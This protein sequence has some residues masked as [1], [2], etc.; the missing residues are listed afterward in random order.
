MTTKKRDRAAYMRQYRARKRE[1]VAEATRTPEPP[2]NAALDAPLGEL[3]A[4]FGERLLVPT[5]PLTGQPF[6]IPPWQRQW[7]IESLAPEV[8]ESGLSV[9]RKNGKSGLVALLVLAFLLRPVRRSTWRAAVVSLTGSL[10]GELL[11]AIVQTATLA[12]QLG[13]LKVRRAPPPGSIEADTG[14]RV[15]FLAS[16]KATGHAIGVD[17]AV[18]DEAGL[19]QETNRELW[20]A[21]YSS[22]SGRDGKLLAISIR[23]D[24]PMFSEMAERAGEPGVVWHEYAAPDDCALDDEQAWHQANPGLATGIKSL[25]YMEDASRKAITIPADA[26]SFRAYDLNQP[27]SPS[28][29]TIC[30]AQD[31]QACEVDDLPPR[32]GYAVVGFDIGGSSSLTALAAFWPATGRLEAWAACGDNPPLLERSRADGVG[33]TYCRMQQRGELA[34][35]PGRV[36]PAAEFLVDCAYRLGDTRVLAAGADRY[37]KAEVLDALSRAGLDWPIE[38]RGQGASGMAD[39]S[40]DVR[41][42]QRLVLGERLKVAPSLLLRQAIAESTIRRDGAGNPALDKRRQHGRID[43]LSAAVIAAGLGE[44]AGVQKPAGSRYRGRV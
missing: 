8:R 28:V 32:D 43:A 25:R 37:R 10:A 35:Y 26:A 20:N 31:W 33:D 39:G 7:L 13:R 36:T 23:G 42:F 38:W 22:T 11:G 5:G 14:A 27:R 44:L 4:R 2:E 34:T 16:D 12:G 30:S 41:A 40:H 6:V 17:L 1:E 15:D 19:L 29:E 9:A 3:V 24:G 21:M 18:I